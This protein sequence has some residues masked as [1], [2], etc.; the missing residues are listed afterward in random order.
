MYTVWIAKEWLSDDLQ[1]I[2]DICVLTYVL[3]T[4]CMNM[5]HFSV[6]EE[7]MSKYVLYVN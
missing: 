5:D 6:T 4:I 2:L 3:C 1:S 7:D